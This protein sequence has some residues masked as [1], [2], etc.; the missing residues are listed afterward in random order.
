M[1]GGRPSTADLQGWDMTGEVPPGEKENLEYTRQATDMVLE[2]LRDQK[3]KPDQEL[4]KQLN[5]TEQDLRRFLQRWEELRRAS[6]EDPRANQQLTDAFRSLGLRPQSARAR[7]VESNVDD[8]RQLN[9]LGRTGGPPSRYLEQYNA[10]KKGTAR[11]D[12]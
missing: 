4:L 3:Q 1:G 8:V 10:Y 6:G 9:E 2:Y 7:R 11:V 12:D 5:W